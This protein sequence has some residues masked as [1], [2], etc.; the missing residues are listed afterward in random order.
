MPQA[1][2][3]GSGSA[4]QG[5]AA[6]AWTLLSSL[7]FPFLFFYRLATGPDDEASLAMLGYF[8]YVGLLTPFLVWA[9]LVLRTP[10]SLAL[11]GTLTPL[12]TIGGFVVGAHANAGIALL[13]AIAVPVAV[14][15]TLHLRE[16]RRASVARCST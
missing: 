12:G 11:W 14:T 10:S 7:V 15:A 3:S 4:L 13:L 16:S 2:A 1:S 6:L 8:F 5:S 9:V